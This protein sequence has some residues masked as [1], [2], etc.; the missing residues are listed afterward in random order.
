MA[1]ELKN[2][3]ELPS[4]KM[5]ALEL[6][7]FIHEKQLIEIYPNLWVALRGA[8]TLPV[9][10]AGAEKSFFQAF[11]SGLSVISINYDAFKKN[12]YDDIIDDFV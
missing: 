1:Q 5:T 10:V 2:F 3:P 7:T 8:V 6:L 4:K 9:T 11:L 12:S